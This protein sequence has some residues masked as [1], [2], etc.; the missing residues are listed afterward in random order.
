MNMDTGHKNYLFAK[1]G[2]VWIERGE[3]GGLLKGEEK[4]G[5]GGG[6]DKLDMS[7]DSL[8]HFLEITL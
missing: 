5:G 8:K 4:G 1:L 3:M 7:F 2:P 6:K